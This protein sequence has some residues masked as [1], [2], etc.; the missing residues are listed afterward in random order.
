MVT[1]TTQTSTTSAAAAAE[2]FTL[3][4]RRR[5]SLSAFHD[6]RAQLDQILDTHQRYDDPLSDRF[7]KWGTDFLVNTSGLPREADSSATQAIKQISK[8][9]LNELSKILRNIF[10]GSPLEKPLLGSDKRVWEELFFNEYKALESRSPFDKQTLTF[11]VHEFAT[12][13]IEWSN[14]VRELIEDPVSS[15]AVA[16]ASAPTDFRAT[17]SSGTPMEKMFLFMSRARDILEQE[18]NESD[19]RNMEEVSRRLRRMRVEMRAETEVAVRESQRR[20]EEAKQANIQDLQALRQTH[21][22][23]AQAQNTRMAESRAR[24]QALSERLAA[25]EKKENEQEKQ[26]EALQLAQIQT[27]RQQQAESEALQAQIE[28]NSRRG[29]GF[30]GVLVQG[31]TQVATQLVKNGL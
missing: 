23:N 28:A 10:D 24:C 20:S 9:E 7:S 4:L 16:A 29:G 13:I 30:L 12:T 17:L 21:E 6:K 8:Q 27:F 2:V 22:A 1:Q 14:S 31:L 5:E 3:T 26:I 15:T 11:K 19:V 25:A 18:E